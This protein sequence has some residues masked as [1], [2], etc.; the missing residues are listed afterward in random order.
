MEEIKLNQVGD[1]G[2]FENSSRICAEDGISPTV[3]TMS[4]GGNEP[5]VAQKLTI[6]KLTE[7]EC[8]KLMGFDRGD[9]E[10]MAEAGLAK[11]TLYHSAGDSIVVTCLMGI[12]GEMMKGDYRSA[13]EERADQIAK[14]KTK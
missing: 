5:K 10:K 3:K 1:L 2:G 11:S 12:F 7:Y 6:R 4:G 14:E 9:F 8:G 13:I